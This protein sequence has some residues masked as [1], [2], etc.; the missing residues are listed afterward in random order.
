MPSFKIIYLYIAPFYWF[1]VGFLIIL[2]MK[3][4]QNN[5]TT[6]EQSKQL[7]EL[8]VPASSADGVY[9]I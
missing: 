2:I 3:N 7:L 5:F 6:V 4:F 8:G 1:K 9:Y